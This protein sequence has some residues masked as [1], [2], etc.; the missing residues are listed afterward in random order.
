M[1]TPRTIP[2]SKQN[3]WR[4][5]GEIATAH[6]LML[7]DAGINEDAVLAALLTALD[8]VSRNP[9]S[10]ED[11]RLADLVARFDERVDALTPA[12][13]VGTVSVA[14]GRIDTTATL[15]RLGL[16]RESVALARSLVH[17]Q[18]TVIDL[19]GQ[20]AATTM[21]A[22]ISGRPAQAT[23]LGHHLGG[24]IA[25]LGRAAE[26]LRLSLE[27]LNQS[28]LGAVAL[29]GTS[30]PIERERTADLLG[31]TG[32][33]DNT[34]DA[35]VAVD[36]VVE[37]SQVAAAI[38]HPVRRFTAELGA[39]LRTNPT[40]FR[41]ADDWTVRE[42]GMPQFVRPIG[43][44]RLLADADAVAANA[45][46]CERVAAALAYEPPGEALDEIALAA[47]AAV[48]TATA[49]VSRLADLL[50]SGLEINRAYLANIAGKGHTTTSDLAIFLMETEGL[51]PVSA[52]NIATMTVNRAIA[53]EIEA[54]GINTQMIDA[55]ALL[56]IGRELAVEF[57]AISR[58][59][60]P[61]RF[62]ERRTAT[63]TPAPARTREYLGR[64]KE[65]L[66]G[67]NG[68]LA[69][70]ERRIDLADRERER[71]VSEALAAVD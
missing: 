30:L 1:E 43:L 11:L 25:P 15:V 33:A 65:R 56:V 39:W 7:R 52:A 32:P 53:D 70:F 24:V 34:F 50:A 45:A 41:L 64:E 9:G 49:L 57:E 17:L 37:I 5:L 62:L 66:G 44:D 67:H 71:L 22:L 35:V 28:P 47:T 63:G 54:S 59:L 10:G 58:Y 12:G 40:S 6:V 42:P 46:S 38:V 2:N 48:Q 31:F 51:D 36:H 14:R 68:W 61:R 21:P 16:R 60:A 27:S 20:H 13:V 3:L 69:Q 4:D 26:R 29:A 23:T 8:G 18:R 55:S 19:A